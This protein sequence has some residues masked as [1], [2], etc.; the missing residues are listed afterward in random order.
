MYESSVSSHRLVIISDIFNNKQRLDLHSNS[1]EPTH[2]SCTK[3]GHTTIILDQLYKHLL[4]RVSF[5]F[6]EK[7]VLLIKASLHL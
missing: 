4:I 1:L 6:D 5:K 3:F 2:I 7:N